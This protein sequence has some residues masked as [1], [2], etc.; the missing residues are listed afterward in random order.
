MRVEGPAAGTRHGGYRL[1]RLGWRDLPQVAALERQVFPEP[2]PLGRLVRVYLRPGVVYLA[3]HPVGHRRLAAYF[4]FERWPGSQGAHVLANATHPADRRRG[5]ARAL[6][7]W[8]TAWARERGVR[9]MVG[10]VRVSNQPQLALLDALGWQVGGRLP[11][12]FGNGEDAWLVYRC[13]DDSP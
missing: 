4:G 11:R 7:T 9:W 12:F 13:L 1:G 8:G 10:E 2:M 3:A 6:L 5:L